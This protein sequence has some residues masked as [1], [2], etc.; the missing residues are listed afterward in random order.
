LTDRWTL[1]CSFLARGR[2]SLRTSTRRFRGAANLS[3]DRREE[4]ALRE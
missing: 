4:A 2:C 3:N 1:H